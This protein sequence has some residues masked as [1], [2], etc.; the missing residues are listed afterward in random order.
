MNQ[1]HEQ[2]A[3]LRVV[4]GAVEQGILA[5]QHREFQGPLANVVVQRRAW[6][7]PE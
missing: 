5:A 3:H 7:L 1:I 2:V 6:L 4:H